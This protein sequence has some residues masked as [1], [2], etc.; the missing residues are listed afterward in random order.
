MHKLNTHAYV[1][2]HR[3]VRRTIIDSSNNDP[4]ESYTSGSDLHRDP[5]INL[6]TTIHHQPN[7]PTTPT[8]SSCPSQL[9]FSKAL[10]LPHQRADNQNPTFLNTQFKQGCRCHWSSTRVA[11]QQDGLICDSAPH[12]YYYSET[13][14]V[15]RGPPKSSYQPSSAHAAIPA[16]LAKSSHDSLPISAKPVIWKGHIANP[17][18]KADP[19]PSDYKP[20]PVPISLSQA[21]KPQSSA[22]PSANKTIQPSQYLSIPAV[23]SPA[24]PAQPAPPTAVHPSNSHPIPAAASPVTL[25]QPVPPK[26][27][28]TSVPV[29]PSV[30]SASKPPHPLRPAQAPVNRETI[31]SPVTSQNSGTSSGTTNNNADITTNNS[32][33]VSVTTPT[34]DASTSSVTPAPILPTQPLTDLGA[35]RQM[36]YTSTMSANGANYTGMPSSPTGNNSFSNYVGENNLSSPPHDSS[37]TQLAKALGGTFG[38]IIG[39]SLLLIAGVLYSRRSSPRQ[40]GESFAGVRR[41]RHSS[42][43]GPP[44]MTQVTSG[45]TTNTSYG[46]VQTAS[47]V[48]MSGGLMS[49]ADPVTRYS[50]NGTGLLTKLQG[51]T[52]ALQQSG[53]ITPTSSMENH[54]NAAQGVATQDP[55]DDSQE[56]TPTAGAGSIHNPFAS[57]QSPTQHTD[58]GSGSGRTISE[59]AQFGAPPRNGQRV[60][61]GDEAWWG[62]AT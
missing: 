47:V 20:T 6:S 24:K 41:S 51:T 4:R 34:L 16:P 37:H 32:S 5:L 49:P 39:L 60:S 30:L 14:A 43:T 31:G 10:D 44:M 17:P 48:P 62:S 57:E 28:H 11:G 50:S 53:L 13:G 25:A 40:R 22:P 38:G 1:L 29:T 21:P 42:L 19:R 12:L 15:I 58:E 52:A 3:F 55:F 27:E 26:D 9:E 46:N 36:V 59:P 33:G 2:P 23:V 35:N 18:L 61:G 54:Q 56:T 7:S 8:H 45:L